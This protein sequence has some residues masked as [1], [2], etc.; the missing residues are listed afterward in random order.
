MLPEHVV[1]NRVYVSSEA[2]GMKDFPFAHRDVKPGKGFLANI[3]H[4]FPR[5]QPGAHFH[6]NQ[7]AEILAKMFLS[8][9]ISRPQTVKIGFVKGLELQVTAPGPRKWQ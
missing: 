9:R 7:R 4:R 8:A 6:L 1:A 3:V 2:L 5:L